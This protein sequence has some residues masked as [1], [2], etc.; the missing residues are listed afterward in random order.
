MA[1]AIELSDH[2]A[3]ALSEAASRLQVPE[4]GICWHTSPP[5]SMLLRNGCS[6]RTRSSTDAWL[7]ALADSAEPR[8]EG[9]TR[10]DHL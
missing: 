5:I 7:D 6:R 8:Y 9:R 3:Q 10:I 4:A 1:I 2:Q